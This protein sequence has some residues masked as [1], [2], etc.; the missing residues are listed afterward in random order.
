[1]HYRSCD[2]ASQI[3]HQSLD[4]SISNVGI[5][6]YIAYILLTQFYLFDHWVIILPH[7]PADMYGLLTCMF[8]TS[9]ECLQR[10]RTVLA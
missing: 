7:D 9:D 2:C 3:V 8:S 6:W 10:Y 1:M 5:N 4:A